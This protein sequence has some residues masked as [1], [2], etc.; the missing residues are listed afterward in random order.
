M[1]VGP[2]SGSAPFVPD[3][4]Q[5]GPIA[6]LLALSAAA[7]GAP[8]TQAP[9]GFPGRN[10]LCRHELRH[11]RAKVVPVN[12]GDWAGFAEMIGGASGALTGLLFVA[13]S[14]NAD[15]ISH[16]RGLRVS[17]VQTLVLFLAPLVVAG[18]LLAPDQPGGFL[19]AELIVTGLVTS[20][21]LL[22]LRRVKQSLSDE[23]QRIIAI[24]NRRAIN[25]TIMLL[26]TASGIVLACGISAGL[27][28]LFP[29]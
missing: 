12:T 1:F 19:G 20:W 29:V 5:G 7:A 2:P 15:R 6:G 14:L 24:F 9:A 8:G 4:S 11:A 16:H 26:L 27:Y 10:K 13:V 3:R 21:I 17:A 25:V 23:D 18:T 22:A 28:L